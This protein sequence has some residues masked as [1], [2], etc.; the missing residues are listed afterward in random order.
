MIFQCSKCH[1]FF[2]KKYNYDLHLRRK[3]PCKNNCDK[4]YNH[5]SNSKLEE[6]SKKI[7]TY[8]SVSDKSLDTY[9]NSLGF[10]DPQINSKKNGYRCDICDKIYKHAQSLYKHKKNNHNKIKDNENIITTKDDIDELKKMIVSLEKQIVEVSNISKNVAKA[11]TI[12]NITNTKTNNTSN[13]NN[14]TINNINIVQFGREDISALT[15]EEIK[16]ILYE[17]GVDGLLASLEVIH[18]NDRLPQYKNLRL[19]NLHSKYIDIHDGKTWIKDD[20]DKIIS[21]TLE[22]HSYN[23]RVLCEENN[24]TKKVKNSIKNFINDYSN[25]NDIDS[26]DKKKNDSKK[27]TKKINSKKDEVKLFVYNKTKNIDNLIIDV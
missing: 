27:L 8:Q 1:K 7:E 18:F 2:S 22:N 25:F 5:D 16:K 6:V 11:K 19:T 17:K 15:K 24:D 26:E 23:L 14:G 13:T 9:S 3:I 12:N 10:I 21:E 4:I 20:K